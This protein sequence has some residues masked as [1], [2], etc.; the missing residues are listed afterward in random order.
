[1]K[2]PIHEKMEELRSMFGRNLQCKHRQLDDGRDA[3]IVAHYFRR[4]REIHHNPPEL[5]P[6]QLDYAADCLG[7]QEVDVEHGFD[8]DEVWGLVIE[9]L[10]TLILTAAK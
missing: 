7:V 1:M 9:K 10:P 5:S 4:P 2:P 8:T 3:I 6:A